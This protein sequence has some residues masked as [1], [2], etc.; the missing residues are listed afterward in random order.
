LCVRS[1][2]CVIEVT[3]FLLRFRSKRLKHMI[4]LPVIASW[5]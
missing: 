1:Q 3:N 4:S 2:V 5:H